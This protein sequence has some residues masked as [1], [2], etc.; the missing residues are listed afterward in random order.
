MT[1]S[2][3]GFRQL[4]EALG[5]IT[6][7]VE[8][9]FDDYE[10]TINLGNNNGGK[11]YLHFEAGVQRMNGDR[12]IAYARSRYSLQ[13]NGDISRSKR[14]MNVIMATKDEIFKGNLLLKAPSIM[15]ALQNQVRTNLHFSEF[16]NLANFLNSEEGRALTREVVFTNRVIDDTF[17]VGSSNP[18]TGFIFIPNLGQGDYSAIQAWVKQAI[19]MP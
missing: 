2:F 17:L 7:K 3:N 9:A 15:S 8:K 19:E 13:E 4:I 16:V 5:G 1:V 14:Q 10:Y 6:V 12:A 11:S 18:L